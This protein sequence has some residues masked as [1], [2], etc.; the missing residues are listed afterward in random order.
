MI[1]IDKLVLLILGAIVF[2]ALIIGAYLFFK[3]Q[4]IDFFK[5]FSTGKPAG[6]FLTLI[7]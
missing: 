2:V 1:A 7:K 6:M 4:V 5:G 3:D